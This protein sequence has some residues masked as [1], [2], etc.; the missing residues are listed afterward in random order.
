MSV[1]LDLAQLVRQ[2]QVGLWRYLR[3]LGALR[4]CVRRLEGRSQQVVELFYGQGFDRAAVAAQ[5]GLKVNGIKTL[6]QRVR[7]AGKKAG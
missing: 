2:H 7:M 6:L 5:M 4:D 3:A 1:E